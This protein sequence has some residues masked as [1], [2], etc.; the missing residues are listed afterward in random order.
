MIALVLSVEHRTPERTHKMRNKSTR[1]TAINSVNSAIVTKGW[2][3]AEL[4]K[5]INRSYENVRSVRGEAVLRK[6][7]ELCI[8]ACNR[9]V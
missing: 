6:M 8:V 2:A 3:P 4:L 5:R 9:N 1:E 7:R